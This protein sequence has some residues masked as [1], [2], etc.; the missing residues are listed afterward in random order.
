MLSINLMDSTLIAQAG[1]METHGLPNDIMYNLNPISVMIIL[2][3]IQGWL[4]QFLNK[5]KI[6]FTMQQ[7]IAVG[8]FFAAVSMGYS[9]GVQQI[10][11]S[12][13]PCFNHP[14]KCLSGDIPN[15]VNVGIQKPTYVFLGVAEILAI[16][17][18]TE[19]AY[20]KAPASMKSI[21]Q[22]IFMFFF[23]LGAVLGVGVS[24]AAYN[25]HLV[26]VYSSIA[27]LLLVATA[28]YQVAI[29]SGCFT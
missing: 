19:L 7:R 13:G 26:I 6:A 16:A 29:F 22:A 28:A 11:Y 17:A 14:L 12:A 3:F 27:A 10:I 4:Y 23:A 1:E 5:H 21:V 9:A 24:F 18:G 2:P 8:L 25:P 20:T 15:E